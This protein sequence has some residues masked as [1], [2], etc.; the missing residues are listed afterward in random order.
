MQIK[1][2]LQPRAG[3]AKQA[4]ANAGPRLG[5]TLPEAKAL[6]SS[7]LAPLRSRVIDLKNAKAERGSNAS[8]TA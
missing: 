1:V 4:F 7:K 2:Y 5:A 8:W 6:R 3:G